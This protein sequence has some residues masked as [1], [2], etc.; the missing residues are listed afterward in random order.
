MAAESVPM[1]SLIR[2]SAIVAC[3][4][5]ALGVSAFA[6]DETSAGSRHQV[7]EIDSGPAARPAAE[8]AQQRGRDRG[9]VRKA[10]DD[11]NDVLLAPFEGIVGSRDR[12]VE[13]LVPAAIAL[14]VYGLGLTLLANAL[15]PPRPR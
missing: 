4:L 13:R 12:W 9:S 14:L 6:I 8:T 7:D 5:V 1:A 10:L 3:V 2:V 15:P 11:A